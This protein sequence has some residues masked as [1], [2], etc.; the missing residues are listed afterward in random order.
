[1]RRHGPRVSA[2][3][4]GLPADADLQ[5]AAEAVDAVRA[6]VRRDI[7]ALALWCVTYGG[8]ATQAGR[9]SRHLLSID[10]LPFFTAS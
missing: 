8:F 3:L 7:T 9:N 1:M 2:R 5:F 10:G 6:R 4:K